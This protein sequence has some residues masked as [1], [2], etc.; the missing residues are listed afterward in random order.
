METLI[1]KKKVNAEKQIIVDL[2][3]HNEGDEIEVVLV[4]SSFSKLAKS[5][6]KIFDMKKWAD[7]WETD[8]GENVQSSDVESFTGRRF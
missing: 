7:Q 3:R 6:R 1:L 2:P 8:L 4:I 5:K